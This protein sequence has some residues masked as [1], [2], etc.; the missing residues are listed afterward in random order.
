VNC[1]ENGCE[2]IADGAATG[3]IGEYRDVVW[4][5]LHGDMPVDAFHGVKGHSKH[6]RIAL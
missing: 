3:F 1:S 6:R 5:P 2:L 4:L